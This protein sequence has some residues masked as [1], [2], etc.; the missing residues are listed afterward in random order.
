MATHA[1]SYGDGDGDGGA[2]WRRSRTADLAAVVAAAPPSS[3]LLLLQCRMASIAMN[4][5]IWK[6][7]DINR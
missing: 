4:A 3:L 2:N 6:I 7:C 1:V 5:V